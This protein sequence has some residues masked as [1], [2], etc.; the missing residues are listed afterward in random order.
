MDAVP[1]SQAY[2]F[3]I[4]ATFSSLFVTMLTA[5]GRVRRLYAYNIL[6]PLILLSSELVGILGW[7]LWGLVWGVVGG[8]LLASLL[9]LGLTL[10]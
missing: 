10:W 1:Y 3:I 4:I 6:S 2:A 8:N 9:S 5:H 7:G